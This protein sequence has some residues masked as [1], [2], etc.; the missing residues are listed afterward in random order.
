[1][2]GLRRRAICSGSFFRGKLALSDAK[3]NLMR[4]KVMVG[5]GGA[6]LLV[7]LLAAYENH[8]H[9]GF[10]MDDGHTI[11][12]NTSIRE[13]RNIP[14]FFTDATTFSALPSNQS[15][16]PLISTLLAIDY[17]LAHGLKPFWF[18]LSVFAL[19]FLLTLLLSLV[20][21]FLLERDASSASNR[22]LALAATLCYAL[23][24]ANADT[25]NYLIASSEVVSALGVVASFAFYFASPRLRRFYLYVLPA[26]LA[27]LA[28]PTAALFPV[29]FALFILCFPEEAGK[30]RVRRWL[31][32]VAPPF[33]I[34]AAVLFFVEWMTPRSWVAGA[35]N[36][37]NYLVTQPYV[38]LLYFKTFFWPTGLNADYDLNPFVTTGDARLWIGVAFVVFMTAVAVV[39]AVFKKTRM[40][41]FGLLWF[42]VAL[43]PTSLF[44]LAEAMNDHR[45]FL[46]YIG[47]V[48]AIAGAAALLAVRFERQ[49]RGTKIAAAC[50]VLLLLCACAYATFHR[51]KV[52]KTEA[53]LWHDV[54]LKSPRNG[55]GL[56]TYGITL[57]NMGR[58][59]EA[60]S[61]LRRAEQLTPPYSVLLIN[62][63]IAEEATGQSEGAEQHFKRALRLAPLSPDSY[64]YYARYLLSQARADEART[65]LQSARKLSP[66][67]R[68]ARELLKE[69]ETREAETH[70]TR[71]DA[72]LRKGRFEEAIAEYETVLKGAPRFGSTLNNFAWLL[73]TCPDGSLRNGAK[74]LEMAETAD[75]LAGG[76]NPVFLRT[77]A[78]AYAESDRFNDAIETAQRALQLAVA[79]QNSVLARNLH[80]DLYLYRNRFPLHPVAAKPETRR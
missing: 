36:A 39:S 69:A 68:N 67:D 31:V 75:G 61:Y 65:L 47:L 33:A 13:L 60:L 79:G 9:N 40:I 20:I 11:V 37:Y 51:N 17:R 78:A 73:S 72:L 2:E 71:G 43:L 62:L 6:L 57:V 7:G 22:S 38:A 21:F 55:R 35:A 30:G 80:K 23:H 27:I 76:K 15:Y 12:D 64:T 42:L 28:K 48:I 10:H 24:P 34:C 18:H 77:R 19:F 29:L 26:A 59:A 50:M 54:V 56:M 3:A 45:A 53:T 63:A 46:P 1:M 49:R 52:W 16:R 74:A 41:G 25:I 66:T 14:R 58:F 44:P 32:E 8:F 4:A 70:A 5:L